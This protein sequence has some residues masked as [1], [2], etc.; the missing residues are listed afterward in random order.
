[1]PVMTS[2]TAMMANVAVFPLRDSV[3]SVFAIIAI[4]PT[5]P[6]AFC[7]GP[8]LPGCAS[9]PCQRCTCET[10]AGA[11]RCELEAAI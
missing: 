8:A 7:T 11:Y 3:P 1:M 9:A 6:V 4:T 2:K 10:S 5:L